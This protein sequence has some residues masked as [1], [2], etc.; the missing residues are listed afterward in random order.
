MRTPSSD[1]VSSYP[2]A[3]R[4]ESGAI[5]NDTPLPAVSVPAGSAN[6]KPVFFRMNVPVSPLPTPAGE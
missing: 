1:T 4:A 5:T 3:P 6:R 2:S